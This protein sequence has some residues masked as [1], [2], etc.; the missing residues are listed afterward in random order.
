MQKI[1]KAVEGSLGHEAGAH[2]G[3]FQPD[4][5]IAHLKTLKPSSPVHVELGIRHGYKIKRAHVELSPEELKAR[6]D[7]ALKI[8][9]E[10][11][12]RKSKRRGGEQ[13]I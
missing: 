8:L 11:M 10:A 1:A 6:E 12:R 3:Y 2:V 4:A 13:N 5:F 7:A 9:T